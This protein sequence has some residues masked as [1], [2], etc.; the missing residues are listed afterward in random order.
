MCSVRVPERPLKLPFTLEIIMCLTLNSAWECAGSSFQVVVVAGV[1]VVVAMGWLLSPSWMRE[2][3]I[4]C[5][6]YF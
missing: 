6:K 3:D 1:E 4:R 5:N 2:E